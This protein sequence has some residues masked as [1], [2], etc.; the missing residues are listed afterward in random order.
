MNASALQGVRGATMAGNAGLA[1]AG[2]AGAVNSVQTFLNGRL[3]GDLGS[4]ALAAAVNNGLA[5]GALL[6]FGAATGA[7]ARLTRAA[8]QRRRPRWWQLATAAMGAAFVIIT[9]TLAPE[10][11]IALLTVAVVCGQSAAS[12]VLDALRAER[13]RE[14]AVDR[15][16]RARAALAV[17]A[18][19]LGAAGGHDDVRVGLLLLGV[20]GGVAFALQ[21]MAV[22][23]MTR[24][25][26]EPLAGATLAVA[27]AGARIWLFALVSTGGTAPGGWSAPPLHWIGGLLGAVVV[28]VV[29]RVVGP[30]GALRLTLALVAGQSVGALVLDIAAPVPGGALT[31]PAV[32]SVLLT[33][34]A[35]TIASTGGASSRR[36]GYVDTFVPSWVSDA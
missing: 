11:G 15:R 32:A 19:A 14:A 27:M 36:A 9:T 10:L 24:D 12:L 13:R 29:A 26:G 23:Y 8:R 17:A 22:G 33:L 34:L 4:A 5:L 31:A 21:Q 1:L 30:Q 18:V 25:T 16:A 20:A 35:V 7:P 28:S 6:V 2:F 3:A